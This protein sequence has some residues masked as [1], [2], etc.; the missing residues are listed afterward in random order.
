MCEDKQEPR[1]DGLEWEV[2]VF[3]IS[4][5]PMCIC[6]CVYMFIQVCVPCDECVYICT[7]A[8]IYFL[9]LSTE[10]VHDHT[11]YSGFRVIQLPT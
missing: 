7:Y 3:R 11:W 5:I 1:R 2:F 10:G 6:I 4:K 9:A 8:C